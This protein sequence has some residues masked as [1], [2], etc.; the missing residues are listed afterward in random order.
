MTVGTLSGGT[1]LQ[2][3]YD[4][5]RADP[6]L[7]FEMWAACKVRWQEKLGIPAATVAKIL[8]SKPAIS[9]PGGTDEGTEQRTT[10]EQAKTQDG[11]VE[12][13]P[14]QTGGDQ[15]GNPEGGG[16]EIAVKEEIDWDASPE[17]TRQL[18]TP[19]LLVDLDEA[20]GD[21]QPSA[22]DIVEG[23]KHTWPSAAT[24]ATIFHNM[25]V[26][27][28]RKEWGMP[29]SPSTSEA[30][31]REKREPEESMGSVP[32]ACAGGE[33]PLDQDDLVQQVMNE[34]KQPSGGA[35]VPPSGG[36]QADREEELIDIE[37]DSGATIRPASQRAKQ[38]G[39]QLGQQL[40]RQ[41]EERRR[42]LRVGGKL[43][44]ED[45]EWLNSWTW[46]KRPN[47]NR[48]R[49]GDTDTRYGYVI[50][51]LCNEGLRGAIFAFTTSGDIKYE[52][53]VQ[54][55]TIP[56]ASRM[57]SSPGTGG[58]GSME[59]DRNQ[60][61]AAPQEERGAR[62]RAHKPGCH[63]RG[64]MHA[65]LQTLEAKVQTLQQSGTGSTVD[66]EFG[67]RKPALIMGGC[68]DVQAFVPGV[69]TAY[70]ILPYGPRENESAQDGWINIKAIAREL[71]QPE[72]DVDSENTGMRQQKRNNNQGDA[73]VAALTDTHDW[74]GALLAHFKQIFTKA[75]GGARDVDFEQ[76]R[77]RLARQCMHKPWVPFTQDELSGVSARWKNTKCTGPDMIAHEALH[78]LKQHPVWERRLRDAQRRRG[79]EDGG[80][81]G[82]ELI[83]TLQT[84]ARDRK[85]FGKN[86]KILTAKTA[87]KRR[88]SE[89]VKQ[90]GQS[91]FQGHTTQQQTH[92]TKSMTSKKQPA[93]AGRP[94]PE[95]SRNNSKRSQSEPWH[96]EQQQQ[97]ATGQPQGAGS[98]AQRP[99]ARQQRTSS[100]RTRPQLATTPQQRRQQHADPTQQQRRAT[101]VPPLDETCPAE[102][103]CG[104]ADKPYHEGQGDQRRGNKH[105][106]SAIRAEFQRRGIDK[107]DHLS[108]N[109]AAHMVGMTPFSEEQQHDGG[110]PPQPRQQGGSR[111]KSPTRK[112]QS[113]VREAA[114]PPPPPNLRQPPPEAT[115][116]R[117]ASSSGEPA[118]GSKEDTEA[119]QK[120]HD[121]M[122]NAQARAEAAQPEGRQPGEER[123]AAQTREAPAAA[124][125]HHSTQPQQASASATEEDP[126][127]CKADATAFSTGHY[128]LQWDDPTQ[129]SHLTMLDPDDGD[130]LHRTRRQFQGNPPNM[131]AHMQEHE[132]QQMSID[133]VVEDMPGTTTEEEMWKGMF[134]RTEQGSRLPTCTKEQQQGSETV[135]RRLR[136]T[137][138]LLPPGE[139][140]PPPP[141][142]NA[143]QIALAVGLMA[144][145]V[146]LQRGTPDRGELLEVQVPLCMSQ[147]GLDTLEAHSRALT[148]RVE[149]LELE[150]KVLKVRV[151][152]LE[153]EGFEL[154][155]ESRPATPPREAASIP[156][157]PAASSPYRPAERTRPSSSSSAAGSSGP[158][159][160]KFRGQAADEIGAYIR[161]CLSGGNRG[162][163]GREKIDLPKVY[164]VVKDFKENLFDPARVFSTWR[165]TQPVVS[166]GPRPGKQFGESI[167]VR[168]PSLRA[169]AAAGLRWPEDAVVWARR[170][171]RTLA[172]LPW[173]EKKDADGELVV[174]LPGG[175]WHRTA[176]RRRVPTASLKSPRS[177]SVRLAAPEA[178]E[179]ALE[180]DLDL[181]FSFGEGEQVDCVPFAPDLVT[182]WRQDR[183]SPEPSHQAVSEGSR[184]EPG[185]AAR[186]ANLERDMGSLQ[187][188]IK[189]ILAR[190]F[191][192]LRNIVCDKYKDE[193]DEYQRYYPAIAF[194]DYGAIISQIRELNA[195]K[196]KDAKKQNPEEYPEIEPPEDER[197]HTEA[198]MEMQDSAKKR[199]AKLLEKGSEKV[200]K[201]EVVDVDD[202]AA[203]KKASGKGKGGIWTSEPPLPAGHWK[204]RTRKEH[205]SSDSKEAKEA[206]RQKLEEHK[207]EKLEEYHKKKLRDAFEKHF[208]GKGAGSD[209]PETAEQKEVR[210]E[211]AASGTG[212]E[213]KKK[214]AGPGPD[215]AGSDP[216]SS[217]ES[218]SSSETNDPVPANPDGS[219]SVKLLV[220]AMLIVRK[221]IGEM[222]APTDIQYETWKPKN[223]TQNC[224][225]EKNSIFVYNGN[226]EVKSHL[227]MEREKKKDQEV[228]PVRMV[229][230]EEFHDVAE[231]FVMDDTDGDDD[232][233]IVGET[234][235]PD[236]VRAV[237]TDEHVPEEGLELIMLDSGLMPAY[238]LVIILRQVPDEFTELLDSTPNGNW[239]IMDDGVEYTGGSG[240][241]KEKARVEAQPEEPTEQERQGD[242][243]Q[244]QGEQIEEVLD[245]LG[246]DLSVSNGGRASSRTSSRSDIQNGPE[247]LVPDDMSLDEFKKRTLEHAE[248]ES[249]ESAAK[250]T[251]EGESSE[252]VSP[253]KAL[254]PPLF[255]G[256][257]SQEDDVFHW[258]EHEDL[259][260]V[261][262]ED[263]EYEDLVEEE[264]EDAP[265][266]EQGESP[267]DVSPEELDSMDQ[268]AAVEELNR[269]S[270][271]GVIEEFAESGASG[272]EKRMD[273]R[274]VYD[275]RYRDGRWRRRCRIVARE[276]RAGAASTAETF[277]PTA[278]NAA[279]RLVLI[280]HLLNPTWVI[281]V[282]DIKDAYLQVPQQEEVLVTISDWMKK[283]CNIGDGI[284]WRLKRCLPGKKEDSL[285]LV[286]ELEKIFRVEKEGPYPLNR[287]GDG[288][289][290]RYLKRKYVFVEEGIVVQPNEK[291]IKKLLEL[292]DLGRL[293]SK[294]TPEH[295]DLVK[296]DKSKDRID[297]QY[298]S[299]LN[300][301][302]DNDEI[303]P[304]ESHVVEAYSDSDWGEARNGYYLDQDQKQG[305]L[306]EDD[307]EWE[308]KYTEDL[309]RGQYDKVIDQPDKERQES[310]VEQPLKGDT[311]LQRHLITTS[312]TL[313]SIRD[314]KDKQVLNLDDLP[315]FLKG[316][317]IEFT[318]KSQQGEFFIRKVDLQLSG[319]LVVNQGEFIALV[320]LHGHGKSS[321]LKMFGGE[322]LP[323]D[324]NLP[325]F[326]VPPHLRVLHVGTEPG[327]F[328]GT[329]YDNLVFGV[330]GGGA[331][332]R[333]AARERVRHVCRLLALPKEILN[334][335]DL[336]DK[337]CWDQ[338]ETGVLTSTMVHACGILQPRSGKR[339]KAGTDSDNAS[340][341]H[342]RT[343]HQPGVPPA[344]TAMPT[345]DLSMSAGAGVRQ[346]PPAAEQQQRKAPQ[347]KPPPTHLRHE[348]AH[349][350]GRAT[351]AA[352]TGSSPPKQNTGSIPSKRQPLQP[353]FQHSQP[354]ALY[355]QVF[356]PP[357]SQTQPPM[358]HDAAAGGTTQVNQDAPP[359]R[360]Q[361][362][363]TGA[364]RAGHHAHGAHD[365]DQQQDEQQQ[366]PAAE[367]EAEWAQHQTAGPAAA[368]EATASAAA[369]SSRA[370]SHQPLQRGVQ[371]LPQRPQHWAAM[372]PWG[373]KRRPWQPPPRQIPTGQHDFHDRPQQPEPDQQQAVESNTDN[374]LLPQH[375]PEEQHPDPATGDPGSAIPHDQ[376]QEQQTQPSQPPQRFQRQQSQASQSQTQATQQHQPAAAQP[377]SSHNPGTQGTQPAQ[378]VQGPY[379][380]Q[381]D[382]PPAD[383]Q[384]SAT[385]RGEQPQQSQPQDSGSTPVHPDSH[386]QTAAASSS[387]DTGTPSSAAQQQH[388]ARY[389]P[390][391]GDQRTRNK[392]NKTWIHAEFA[393]RGTSTGDGEA[394]S[395][396]QPPP[397]TAA[398]SAAGPEHQEDP[399]SKQG[400]Q[401]QQQA[402]NREGW[403]P[404][405]T[406]DH[407]DTQQQQ[408]PTLEGAGSIQARAPPNED[409]T[410]KDQLQR[411]LNA[412]PSNPAPPVDIAAVLK[413]QQEWVTNTPPRG[414]KEDTEATE[415]QQASQRSRSPSEQQGLVRYRLQLY[416]TT[417]HTPITWPPILPVGPTMAIVY[418]SMP[419]GDES[420]TSWP[421][422]DRTD[423]PNPMNPEESDRTELWQQS[424][425]LKSKQAAAAPA[426]TTC[427]MH[428]GAPSSTSRYRSQ[429]EQESRAAAAARARRCILRVLELTRGEA[430]LQAQQAL[431]A[432]QPPQE[433]GPS[434]VA[435]GASSS[436]EA[437][438]T[439][440]APPGCNQ[441]PPPNPHQTAG[442]LIELAMATIVALNEMGEEAGVND[443][444]HDLRQIQRLLKE[445][446]RLFHGAKKARDW[447]AVH[448]GE[449][450]A[451]RA[452]ECC[453]SLLQTLDTAP[454]GHQ[455]Y[456]LDAL[457]RMQYL[458]REASSAHAAAWG[459]LHEE[460]EDLRSVEELRPLRKRPHH[461]ADCIA[462]DG[463]QDS[464]LEAPTAQQELPL[465]AMRK[466]RRLMPFLHGEAQVL[467]GDALADLYQWSTQFWGD[468][469]TLV[470]D[471]QEE[472]HNNR[473]NQHQLN[474]H[475][476]PN[477]NYHRDQDQNYQ[478]Y[479]RRRQQ[480]KRRTA[481][482]RKNRGV[483]QARDQ[484]QTDNPGTE[485]SY[486]EDHDE[487][488][489]RC[490]LKDQNRDYLHNKRR[491]AQTRRRTRAVDFLNL[492]DLNHK[493][494]Y[495]LGNKRRRHQPRRRKEERHSSQAGHYQKDEHHLLESWD[496]TQMVHS[497]KGKKGS[498]HEDHGGN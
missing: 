43:G 381:Q 480:T 414:S 89:A 360:R 239:T 144:D 411:Y 402:E 338:D 164:V 56:T 104:R 379:Q 341:E 265:K 388:W 390:G 42:T 130:L 316:P 283:A 148:A 492:L 110:T 134:E 87:L 88:F 321:I 432:L 467:A 442:D 268:E 284:V 160:E 233:C 394:S 185:W 386:Q 412:K 337:L 25:T 274:E 2:M 263:T 375:Q 401:A 458:A 106:K 45:E 29:S 280:L 204:D 173:R 339:E 115:P 348:E 181:G 318:V 39:E 37:I 266:N 441:P 137:E 261:E 1:H 28:I 269:L 408:Q 383:S 443:L 427:L 297:I 237:R 405:T 196:Y 387:S 282:L 210:T 351:A 47:A 463:G 98:Y 483:K 455:P 417:G 223:N 406:P 6:L 252:P 111:S 90:H 201:T 296:E 407:A 175:A 31:A 220:F 231:W 285:W 448:R 152:R 450:L 79:W 358:E 235:T 267:P 278:S 120:H 246:T 430:H 320:G 216:S 479:K 154:V 475:E 49:A 27:D 439:G 30:S 22:D 182:S 178:R 306:E 26:T 215:E 317:R 494:Q 105:T 161:R 174:A 51:T 245:M 195:A 333:D 127:E 140:P 421:S 36:A 319:D 126:C 293:K 38:A 48:R 380:Q 481:S 202:D 21:Q 23:M 125:H 20:S 183:F 136:E 103:K 118:P 76:R 116:H 325:G 159:A 300:G 139:Q 247:E 244:S 350:Q 456:T 356:G 332:Y 157:C 460:E 365:D 78:I 327:L 162:S 410:S 489:A 112:G 476:D 374:N 493:K 425:Q 163:S 206:L 225:L 52:A 67:G 238:C 367:P 292:Y 342:R 122:A 224:I 92:G 262:G 227:D 384:S 151:E 197:G 155:S 83:L 82:T 449:D 264:M 423:Q 124:S 286:E 94:W 289:E 298:A 377:T 222:N 4:Q 310:A 435:G 108:W 311:A 457:E 343:K 370:R 305:R 74:Q 100:K 34:L 295:V 403:Q 97:R 347:P 46:E 153:G 11:R 93:E 10:E 214:E 459:T 330:D 208:S 99:R 259:T 453:S 143:F 177:F 176:T 166:V 470:E 273:L 287:I 438:H 102:S 254:Y 323:G 346:S 270:K 86:K 392:A 199:R 101:E 156:S 17:G 353:N 24:F 465:M 291:Y 275:W 188:G 389:T 44:G 486:H 186:V 495:D 75:D 487:N 308:L 121:R 315:L 192:P 209:A 422:E 13:T 357:P 96:P 217:E 242:L 366:Q 205:L 243:G 165:D 132:L 119:K 128:R 428:G 58:G 257:V 307:S 418:Q 50:A 413:S 61:P 462:H 5:L 258:D 382:P 322:L 497:N 8:A 172:A 279:A 468:I 14:P 446:E 496:Q 376:T 461:E 304:E 7:A 329:L 145:R 433:A 255:A 109:E 349:P 40:R 129:Q 256:R 474:Y 91:D 464:H 189:D 404:P 445:G 69:R 41:E 272:S 352:A 451:E 170:R 313:R 362:L 73:W 364:M 324:G 426:E 368:A 3:A 240:E 472:R 253:S 276:Y 281:L 301:Q 77:G 469:I 309:W 277:S 70:A 355:R 68:V 241:G 260:A 179:Q 440:P 55:A 429:G 131:S 395:S 372:E 431:C 471:S 33:P 334:L 437:P 447:P 436:H 452:A 498:Y 385:H 16:T 190:K 229:R 193:K 219:T 491:R 399:K 420:E 171:L 54:R 53:V 434:D 123:A 72:S 369:S 180:A 81:R 299:K 484:T 415:R 218:E 147:T 294:A 409:P 228:D 167:F 488:Q 141:S 80:T 328:H 146:T 35:P 198:L 19:E 207:K 142:P 378:P 213:S 336:P 107:P 138:E 221:D 150:N 345:L 203:S 398:A 363:G 312:T 288:E 135:E 15:T 397:N 65:R 226:F 234:D 303:P 66:T 211:P 354:T 361:P 158:A 184:D 60:E 84:V 212:D 391:A 169:V 85:A 236:V 59:T 466:L 419:A 271:I 18:V 478:Y 187:Q 57:N 194:A 482:R 200:Q 95:N 400:T 232:W 416:L 477:K 373:R 251:R 424:K 371:P 290:L 191:F 117:T 71:G 490:Y 302:E 359:Q 344:D 248:L 9:L 32:G 249:E 444:Q 326:F 133:A 340:A 230:E 485:Q 12:A 63:Q 396:S 314:V 168:F 393:K 473:E 335:L 114:Q 149:L 250:K 113:Q 331:E 64:R 62:G 454:P